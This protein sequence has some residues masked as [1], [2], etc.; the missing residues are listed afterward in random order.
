M[1]LTLTLELETWYSVIPFILYPFV[2]F[3]EPIIIDIEELGLRSPVKVYYYPLIIPLLS[4][5]IENMF[6][7]F[8]SPLKTLKLDDWTA[9]LLTVRKGIKL[10]DAKP[11]TSRVL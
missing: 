7:G 1:L 8:K 2:S 10:N 3:H 6:F 4:L 11:N 9:C 5:P